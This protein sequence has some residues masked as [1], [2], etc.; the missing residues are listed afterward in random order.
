MLC[1]NGVTISAECAPFYKKKSC[2]TPCVNSVV[3]FKVKIDIKKIMITLSWYHLDEVKFQC[4]FSK[5]E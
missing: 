4:E 2:F 5:N 1:V 3:F